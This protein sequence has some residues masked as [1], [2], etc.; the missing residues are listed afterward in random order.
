MQKALSLFALCLALLFSSPAWATPF[1]QEGGEA[2]SF[3][4]NTLEGEEISLQGLTSDSHLLLI[5]WTTWCPECS[6][7]LSEVEHLAADYDSEDLAI[8]GINTGVDDTP[9]RAERFRERHDLDIPLAFD[10]DSEIT[11][12]YFIQGIPTLFVVDPGGKVTFKGNTLSD[13][14]LQALDE[15]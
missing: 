10:R 3:R 14:L 2:P 13:R 7:T 8:L 5:F 11:Q 15:I 6:R 9:E 1:L 12:D 4:V